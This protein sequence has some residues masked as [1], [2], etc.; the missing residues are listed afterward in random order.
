MMKRKKGIFWGVVLL[1]LAVYIIVGSLGYFGD[2]GFWTILFSVA[3]GA[4][5]FESLFKLRWGGILFSLAF[6]AILYDERLSIEA[7]TPWPVLFA[8][9]FGSIGLS[10]IFRKSGSRYRWGFRTHEGTSETIG[11]N[12]DSPHFHCEKSFGSAVRYVKSRSL[13][14]VTLENAFG[15]LVVYLDQAGLA[16]GHV[17]IS[18]ENS[19]GTLELYVPKEWKV[20]LQTVESFGHVE[21]FGTSNPDGAEQA[22]IVA[23]TS[24]G[25][26][27]IHYV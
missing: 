2:L 8:A 9:L 5:F 1:L 10:L 12:P 26:I 6:L 18:A 22:V 25:C 23:E 3:L 19:F 11:D 4:W 24:F 7:L 16:D 27:E 13:E 21:E 20:R 15:S 17:S 14:K